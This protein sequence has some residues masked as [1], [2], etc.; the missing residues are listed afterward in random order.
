MLLALLYGFVRLLLDLLLVRCRS[1]ASLRS[2]VLLLRHKG[3]RPPAPSPASTP[4]A[5]GSPAPGG[6]QPPAAA[7]SMGVLPGLRL[8]H[9]RHRL[10]QAALRALLHCDTRSRTWL[11]ASF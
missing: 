6:A 5:R 11:S 3:S 9:R 7:T 4:A 2:E 1:E 10:A 8:L